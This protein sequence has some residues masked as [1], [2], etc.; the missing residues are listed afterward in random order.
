MQK[1]HAAAGAQCAVLLHE[2]LRCRYGV[3]RQVVRVELT[4][5]FARARA[6]PLTLCSMNFKRWEEVRRDIIKSKQ[7]LIT[8]TVGIT[9][10][11][12]NMPD[13]KPHA[14]HAPRPDRD[15]GR[16]RKWWERNWPTV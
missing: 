10:A 7:E 8:E 12:P 5:P 2:N 1:A 3:P 6:C 4:S 16:E 14:Y 11:P 13:M 9:K 15:P